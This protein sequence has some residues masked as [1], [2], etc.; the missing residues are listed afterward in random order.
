MAQRDETK[1]SPR[2]AQNTERQSRIV[3]IDD[4]MSAIQALIAPEL[5]AGHEIESF[6]VRRSRKGRLSL[7]YTA[8]VHLTEP[9]S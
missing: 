6:I 5:P 2:V 3:H 4:A 7:T 8:S 9:V 1:E